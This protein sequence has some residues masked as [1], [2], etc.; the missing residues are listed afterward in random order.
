[1]ALIMYAGLVLKGD[2]ATVNVY[3]AF[4]HIPLGPF[5]CGPR[6]GVRGAPGLP[7]LGKL[8]PKCDTRNVVTVCALNADLRWAGK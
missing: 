6:C 4:A 5:P 2:T 3:R 8:F 1:V 7:L